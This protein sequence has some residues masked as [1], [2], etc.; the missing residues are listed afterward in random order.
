MYSS[1]GTSGAPPYDAAKWDGDRKRSPRRYPRMWPGNSWRSLRADTPFEASDQ[2]GDGDLGRVVRRQV[3]V[4]AFEHGVPREYEPREHT[5]AELKTQGL[6]ARAARHTIKEARDASTTSKANIRAGN[7]VKERSERRR[8]AE[9]EP[10][11]FRSESARPYDDRCS[12]RRYDQQT[13]SI[14]TTSGRLGPRKKLQKKRAESATRR[15][16]ARARKE[17]RHSANQKHIV[18][19]T[20]VTEAERT[21]RGLSLE[22]LKGIRTRVRL[23]KPP[24][25]ALHSRAFARLTDFIVHKIQRAGVPLVFVDPAYTSRMCSECRHIGKQD[26]ADQGP[27]MCRGCGVVAHADRNAS[28]PPVARAW[29]TRGVSHASLSPPRGVRTEEPIPA[30]SRARPPRPTLESRVKSTPGRRPSPS[31]SA[32]AVR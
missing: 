26:R 20:I 16:E 19:K 15:L 2:S 21:G 6:G 29:G 13:V 22:E 24:R 32:P 4:I 17:A 28:P 7:L 27:F 23:R 3:Y 30:A 11:V 31:R 18:S 14:W 12:S 25:V 8:K 5:Y 1:T 10:I 9:P